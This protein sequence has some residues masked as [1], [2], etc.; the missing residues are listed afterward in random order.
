MAGFQHSGDGA[1]W[2]YPLTLTGFGLPAVRCL[3][4]AFPT[5]NSGGLVG[6]RCSPREQSVTYCTAIHINNLAP[7]PFPS[8]SVLV[9]A[10]LTL[11]GD[12]VVYTHGPVTPQ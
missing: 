3:C 4:E 11:E 10:L 8:I 1:V 7:L 12:S 9:S 5:H 6:V 2:T